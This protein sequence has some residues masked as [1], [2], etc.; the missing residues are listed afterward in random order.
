MTAKVSAK[1]KEK[2]NRQSTDS[3]HVH[4]G[5][6]LHHLAGDV[7]RAVR[8]DSQPAFALHRRLHVCCEAG[9][10]A[11]QAA[12]PAVVPRARDREIHTHTHTHTH[13][14]R[15]RERERG[16]CSGAASACS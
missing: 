1:I 3:L 10:A 15:E 13:R 5:A 4:R 6:A 8:A 9:G 11:E 16:A 12:V 7:Y 14:E 2:P